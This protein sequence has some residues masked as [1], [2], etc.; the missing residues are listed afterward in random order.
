MTLQRPLRESSVYR[1]AL[2]VLFAYFAVGIWNTGVS[3]RWKRRMRAKFTTRQDV[4]GPNITHFFLIVPALRESAVIFE[5]ISALRRFDYPADRVEIVIALDAKEDGAITTADV[6]ASYLAEHSHDGSNVTSVTFHGEQQRRSLQLNAALDDV[7]NRVHHRRITG[8]VVVGVYDADSRPDP[9]T[10]AYIDWTIRTTRRDLV[11]F[12]QTVSYLLNADELRSTPLVHANAVYQSVWNLVFETSRLLAS[13]RA[14]E[15]NRPLLFP[16]YCIGHGEFFSLTALNEIGGFPRTGPCDGIQI[17]FALSRAAIPVIPVPFDDSCQSP[18]DLRTIVRQHTYWYSGN[19]QFFAWYRPTSLDP[20]II[21]ANVCHIALNLKWLLRPVW[22]IA[23]V[24]I[25]AHRRHW[26]TAALLAICPTIYYRII[27]R[28]WCY[29]N[30]ESAMPATP[31]N[32]MPV[33]AGYKSIGAANA[34]LRILLGKS[35]FHKTER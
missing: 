10:L 22:F 7:R 23:I 26:L 19:L 5:T 20:K 25:A 1:C 30:D 2:F 27:A 4:D 15:H 17:G 21:A 3:A 6:V 34:L 13:Q 28:L 32:W 16:P 12:Q 31:V 24:V 35:T 14:C 8:P 18:T 9:R 11:A 33:A 29:A